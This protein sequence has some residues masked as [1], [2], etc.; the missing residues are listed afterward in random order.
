M[1]VVLYKWAVWGRVLWQ[2]VIQIW[3]S[4]TQDY[5]EPCISQ[6]GTECNL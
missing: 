6:L 3:G 2:V 5:N 1:C 4:C